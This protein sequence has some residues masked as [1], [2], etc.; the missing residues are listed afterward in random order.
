MRKRSKIALAATGV[1]TA[2]ALSFFMV[3]G[4]PAAT[5]VLTDVPIGAAA[6]AF[7]LNDVNGRAVTLAQFRGKP[8][9]LEW[10][11]PD[12]PTVKDYYESG[13]MQRTQADATAGGAVWLTVNSSAKWRQ[14]HMS[15]AEAKRFAADQQSP[16]TAYLL[17]PEGVVGRSYAARTTPHVYVISPAGKLVYRGA[18]YG[19]PAEVKADNKEAR[20]H[21]LAA[22]SEMKAGKSVSVPTSRPYGCAVKYG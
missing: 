18:V 4:L 2:S 6:P 12:C 15:P 8:V 19:D 9:V 3:A 1:V 20:N 17:D 5:P 7:Q 13:T 21:V 16:R 14:G 11:N 10:N 22:L